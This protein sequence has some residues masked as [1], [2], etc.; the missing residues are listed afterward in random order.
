M[1]YAL[2]F[3]ACAS[4]NFTASR[5]LWNAAICKSVLPSSF[6]A[7]MFAPNFYKNSDIS[8]RLL[9]IAKLLG[10]SLDGFAVSFKMRSL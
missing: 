9:R 5:F 3:E 4:A 6:G 10:E 8:G 2:I 7:K 1:F